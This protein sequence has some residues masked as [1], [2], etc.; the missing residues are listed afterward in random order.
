M[1]GRVRT[2]ALMHARELGRRRIAMGLLIAMPLAFYGSS[3]SSEGSYVLQVGGTGVAWSLTGAGLFL[4]LGSR[5]L[6]P[7]LVLAGYRPWEIF[8]GQ[9]LL[10]YALAAPLVGLFAAI[11]LA[12]EQPESP[13][14][15][16]AAVALTAGLAAPLGMLLGSVA[17]GDLEGTLG[18][19][20]ILG[21]QMSLPPTMAGGVVLPFYGP[22]QLIERAYGSSA[23]P[24][25]IAVAHTAVALVVLA[26]LALAFWSRR[27]RIHLSGT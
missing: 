22:V 27:T 19:I 15:F 2:V 18:L 24:V 21:I 6:A 1:S 9:L 23:D 20:A 16:G 17:P 12:V 25:G 13:A 8:T 5:R 3:A 4:G 11:V 14:S 26:A 7:R 10:L